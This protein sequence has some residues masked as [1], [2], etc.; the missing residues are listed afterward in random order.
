MTENTSLSLP[1][2]VFDRE[3]RIYWPGEP[4][5]KVVTIM[6]SLDE[7]AQRKLLTA[8]RMIASGRLTPAAVVKMTE[9]ELRAYVLALPEDRA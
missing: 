4:Q 7:P 9:E 5:H 2:L 8:A 6:R 1:P 3:G